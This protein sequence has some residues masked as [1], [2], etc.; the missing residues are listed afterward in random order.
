MVKIVK[1]FIIANKDFADNDVDLTYN[2]WKWQLRRARP[3]KKI[4][5]M[6]AKSLMKCWKDGVISSPSSIGRGRRKCQEHYPETRGEIY[7][8]RMNRQEEVKQ[9]LRRKC[10][11]G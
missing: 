9:D 8:K 10:V 5:S 7:A 11:K 1:G 3:P 6:T 4:E 2:I